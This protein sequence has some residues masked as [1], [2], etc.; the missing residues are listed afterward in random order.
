MKQSHNLHTHLN[1]I[2]VFDGSKGRILNNMISS[3]R[4]LLTLITL[5]LLL[6]RFVLEIIKGKPFSLSIIIGNQVD[7]SSNTILE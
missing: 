5:L 7:P 6:L 4:F 2:R 1:R 3:G